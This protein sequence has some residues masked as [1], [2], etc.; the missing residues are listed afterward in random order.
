MFG[1]RLIRR[2]TPIRGG[3]VLAFSIGLVV[4]IVRRGG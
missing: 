1:F 2:E 4:A 3:Q